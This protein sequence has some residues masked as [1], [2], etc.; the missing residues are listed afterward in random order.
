MNEIALIDSGCY[1][2]K[3]TYRSDEFH[4]KFDL[5]WLYDFPAID[6]TLYK[7]VIIPTAI[8]EEFLFRY[9]KKLEKYLDNGGIICSFAQNFLT[10]LPGN[11][12]WKPSE[13][14]F[15]DRT[16]FKSNDHPIFMG[17]D[18]YDLNYRGGVKGFFSRGFFEEPV[19]AEV[20]LHD[21]E[22]R[23]VLY[24]DRTTTNGIIL[25]GAGSDLVSFGVGSNNT[26]ELLV[27][28]LLDWILQEAHGE[29]GNQ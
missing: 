1:F 7:G 19:G 24:I 15:K 16:I 3:N 11:S 18:E 23:T 14:P 27:P 21:N 26:S 10:W 25:S 8:D 29:K 20:L 4:Q 6:L 9:R 5:I 17:V 12:L 13:I 22:H 28:Q 2:G